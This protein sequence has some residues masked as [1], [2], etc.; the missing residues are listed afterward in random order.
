VVQAFYLGVFERMEKSKPTLFSPGPGKRGMTDLH[1]AAY[2]G[3]LDA[4]LRF[5]DAGLAVNATDTYRGYTPT[6][7]L[8][9]MAAAGGPRVKM[10]RALVK[11]GADI[12]I[13]TP[14]GTTAL[15]LAR[16]AGSAGGH[17]LAAEL[18]LSGATE[19]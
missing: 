13:K 11:Y 10:L 3:D 19:T 16:E 7:W 15:M 5:L 17:E 6:H 9:D 4:L 18:I 14:N 8:A 1:Y 12:N 2:C